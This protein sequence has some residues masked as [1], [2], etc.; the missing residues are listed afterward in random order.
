MIHEDYEV[1]G[2]AHYCAVLHCTAV[3]LS[4]ASSCNECIEQAVLYN[5]A[6]P[7][8]ERVFTK[9]CSSM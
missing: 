2:S 6:V 8:Y 3:V 7:C 9:Q 5:A 4:W 1:E